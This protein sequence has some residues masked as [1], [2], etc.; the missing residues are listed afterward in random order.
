MNDRQHSVPEPQLKTQSETYHETPPPR[1]SSRQSKPPERLGLT[2]NIDDV[3]SSDGQMDKGYHKIKRV[4]GQRFI[5][6]THEYLVQ[7]KGEP[8]E[9]SIWVPLSS[10]SPTAL[11]RVKHFPPPVIVDMQ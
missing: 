9:N 8:S 10:L 2:V 1:R 5:N 11:Q 3:I 7:I 4:L 6:H